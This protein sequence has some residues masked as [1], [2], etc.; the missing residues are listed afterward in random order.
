MKRKRISLKLMLPS[1]IIAIGNFL[2]DEIS[3]FFPSIY[4]FIMGI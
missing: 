3:P 1:A 2:S 4:D